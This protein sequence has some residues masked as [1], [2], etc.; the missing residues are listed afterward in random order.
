MKRVTSGQQMN[1]PTKVKRKNTKKEKMHESQLRV[2][3]LANGIG[4]AIGS[5]TV[6]KSDQLESKQK[7]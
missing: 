1:T 5:Y 4:C 6:S 2:Y 3:D 7:Y